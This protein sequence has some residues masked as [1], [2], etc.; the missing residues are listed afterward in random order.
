[1]PE[2]V[3]DPTFIRDRPALTDE[4]Q[5]HTRLAIAISKVI[6]ADSDTRVIGLVG[7]WGSGKSTILRFAE[8]ELTSQAGG[9]KYHFFFY[10]AWLHEGD[11]PRRAFIE[12][13]AEF[14][15]D[16][17]LIKIKKWQDDLDVI[18]RRAETHI[19]H[20]TPAFT[21]WGAAIAISLLFFPLGIRLAGLENDIWQISGVFILC[22]P[23]IFL[24][25]NY[26]AWRPWDKWGKREFW[27]GKTKEHENDNILSLFMTKSTDRIKN[28]IIK[29]PDPTS[30]EF[31]DLF[32]RLMA[33]ITASDSRFVFVI[34]NIDR[35]T[36]KEAVASTWSTIR[37]FFTDRS[38]EL[39]GAT[40]P[41]Y[42]SP[43]VIL[44]LDV[45]AAARLHDGTEDELSA[46]ALT[47]LMD[48]T[49]DVVFHV[50]PPVGSDWQKYLADRIQKVLGPTTSSEDCHAVCRLYELLV[51]VDQ[52]H[53]A[54]APRTLNKLV[55]GIA[56]LHLTWGDEIPLIAKGYYSALRSADP[57][58]EIAKALAEDSPSNALM[59]EYDSNWQTHLA[60][61]HYGV[62]PARVLQVVV[63][64]EI[65]AAILQG[66]Q[67]RFD[68]ASNIVGWGRTLL[69]L[70]ERR[71]SAKTIE[72]SF[73]ANTA[74]FLSE[75]AKDS[76]IADVW[77]ALAKACRSFG[78]P[79]K[80]G[81]GSIEGYRALAKNTDAAGRIGII[82][83]LRQAS[84]L[85]ATEWNAVAKFTVEFARVK[86]EKFSKEA[87]FPADATYTLGLL[88]DAGRSDHLDEFRVEDDPTAKSIVATVAARIKESP[89]E[90]FDLLVRMINGQ[91]PWVWDPVKE[92]IRDGL[93]GHQPAIAGKRDL[94][95]AALLFEDGSLALTNPT[96][97]GGLADMMARAV[98]DGDHALVGAILS[99]YARNNQDFQLTNNFGRV[100][101]GLQYI[102]NPGSLSPPAMKAVVSAIVELVYEINDANIIRD[103]ISISKKHTEWASLA[104]GVLRETFEPS[105]QGPTIYPFVVGRDLKHVL[106]L[107]GTSARPGVI[108]KVSDYK[109]VAKQAIP[110]LNDDELFEFASFASPE[111]SKLAIE[112][113]GERWAEKDAKWWVDEICKEQSTLASALVSDKFANV[114]TYSP[115]VW[116][117]LQEVVT[118]VANGELLE[119]GARAWDRMLAL[120]SKDQRELLALNAF[121]QLYAATGSAVSAM[122]TLL[123]AD[124]NRVITESGDSFFR[125][126]VLRLLHEGQASTILPISAALAPAARKMKPATKREIAAALEKAR[127]DPALKAVAEAAIENWINPKKRKVARNA[128]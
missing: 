61:L 74:A 116:V 81:G 24:L 38:E 96:R 35:V 87:R 104:G 12:S 127:E 3:T 94:L 114:F 69:A 32:D 57:K 109:G 89:S 25:V 78:A 44:P 99:A 90:Q 16:R 70:V 51:P 5:T 20:S 22:L 68:D 49:F 19:V 88:N 13:F 11:P 41:R 65:E 34:D 72:G 59:A 126:V 43:W 66:D 73:L 36:S 82:R 31:K 30:L 98:G 75:K 101:E 64:P 118:K 76:H 14:L 2:V 122:T 23:L 102:R 97:Q 85:T 119:I 103:L 77:K 111:A 28:K 37:G 123:G 53:E 71:L 108:R 27:Y 105:R 67:S 60:A 91:E 112:K 100:S 55:N 79:Y 83:A 115:E 15:A 110:T 40:R 46:A 92:V 95:R 7:P 33:S 107:V 128:E 50:G 48:K 56:S 106:Q 39:E 21:F 42:M 62:P 63:G 18:S 120:L 6:N 45:D 54:V 84:S 8:K 26:V 47:G 52:T 121:E 80:S 29:T 86:G 9:R 1:M 93:S 4:F 17:D 58:L 124:I 10:D 117:A 113:L 125:R